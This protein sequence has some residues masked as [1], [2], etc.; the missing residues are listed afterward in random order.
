MKKEFN[1]VINKDLNDKLKN[2][3]KQK[4]IPCSKAVNKIIKIMLPL[5]KKHHFFSKEN[6]CKYKIIFAVKKIHSYIDKK[7]YRELKLVHS[8]LNF[9]SIAILVRYLLNKFFELLEK[10]NGRVKS[11][12]I[13]M[14]KFNEKLRK[15]CEEINYEIEKGRKR[16]KQLSRIPTIQIVYT[17]RSSIHNIKI[18]SPNLIFY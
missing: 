3:C 5:I 9:Y 7:I 1:F 13:G 10:R 16:K 11:V 2:Y 12:K 17:C 4:N 8:N 6:N 18:L 14:K 15:R